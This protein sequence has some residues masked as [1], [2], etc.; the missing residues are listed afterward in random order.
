MP[1]TGIH[2]LLTY[3]YGVETADPAAS[4]CHLCYRTRQ[5]LRERFPEFLAPP[6]LYGA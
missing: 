1:L 3:R 4:A 6:G 2:F 5:R